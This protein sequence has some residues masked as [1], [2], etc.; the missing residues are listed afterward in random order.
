MNGGQRDCDNESPYDLERCT[1]VVKFKN[2]YKISQIPDEIDAIVIY[3][4]SKK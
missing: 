1:G 2:M 3:V 4:Q